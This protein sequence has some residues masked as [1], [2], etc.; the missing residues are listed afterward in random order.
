MLANIS[1]SRCS[2]K[3]IH[4]RMD[5]DIRIRMAQKSFLIRNLHATQDQFSAFHQAMDIISH[6]YP[7]CSAP[8]L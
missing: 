3:S 5:Q 6:S 7:H 4:D 1:Q 8:F 2:Q